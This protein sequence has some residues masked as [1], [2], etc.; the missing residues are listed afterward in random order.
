MFT[1]TKNASEL[2]HLVVEHSGA[3]GIRIERVSPQL[4]GTYEIF[5]VAGPRADD[6]VLNLDGNDVF[7]DEI[8]FL[9]LSD[10]ILDAY[11]DPDGAATFAMAPQR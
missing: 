3:G 1:L 8:A 6:A 5:T 11:I 4:P 9:D 10:Q 2:L 7:M